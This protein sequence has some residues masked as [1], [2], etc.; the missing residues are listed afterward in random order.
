[1]ITL[2]GRSSLAK[3][4]PSPRANCLYPAVDQFARASLQDALTGWQPASQTAR[5]GSIML[6][7][8]SF[9]TGNQIRIL[10]LSGVS[11]TKIL[12]PIR[13]SR[14]LLRVI[15]Y[16]SEKKLAWIL[17]RTLIN[18]F[19][20]YTVVSHFYGQITSFKLVTDMLKKLTRF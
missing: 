18:K 19:F 15:F 10:L 17:E 11:K 4:L 14:L 1:M 5:Q 7:I 6:E 20:L 16:F 9:A 2:N 12:F 8:S 13:A 3:R